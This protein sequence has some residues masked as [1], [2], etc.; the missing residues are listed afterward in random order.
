MTIVRRRHTSMHCQV[1]AWALD[2]DIWECPTCGRRWQYRVYPNPTFNTWRQTL[3]SIVFHRPR[4]FL[5]RK[6][7]RR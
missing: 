4:W 1:P 3:A 6:D 5:L 2:R 7:G